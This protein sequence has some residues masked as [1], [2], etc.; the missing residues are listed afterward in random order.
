MLAS[1][2]R[3][4]T[5][6]PQQAEIISR[7]S[8]ALKSGYRHVILCAPTGVGKSHVAMTF[9]NHHGGG[10]IVTRQRLLQ[11][12]YARDFAGLPVAMG[13]S[14]YR[15]LEL[16]GGP[17]EGAPCS[18][19][20]CTWREG[21]KK[22]TCTRKPMPS[23]FTVLPGGTVS[24][25][26]DSC[27]YYTAKYTAMLSEAAVYNYASFFHF[28]RHGKARK[29]TL[30]CDEAHEIED[31]LVAHV[32]HT[33]DREQL[34]ECGAEVG[35]RAD[36]DSVR[37]ALWAIHADFAR[38]ARGDGSNVNYYAFVAEKCRL[39]IREA[40]ARPDNLVTGYG[41]GSRRLTVTMADVSGVA[42]TYFDAPRQ[43]FMS[44]T[45]SPEPFCHSMGI[46]V[47]DAAFVEVHDSPFP[48]ENRRIHM[49]DVARINERTTPSEH[50]A[51]CGRVNEVMRRHS[52]Q[53]GLILAT[54]VARCVEII[55]NAEEPDRLVPVFAR[56]DSTREEQLARHVESEE[57]TVL[58][59]PSL[60]SG[61]DL[62]G[63]LSEWQVIYK[64]PYPSM[65]DPRVRR[66]AAASQVWYR[67]AALTR[68][69]QGC[70]RSV[71][72]EGDSA[73]TYVIDSGIRDLLRTMKR[74]VPRSYT[75]ALA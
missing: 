7:I 43:L 34:D 15:C 38:R 39:L 66:K 60:W 1:F 25:P 22:M 71:R 18:Q 42:R 48:P 17:A 9:L 50:L 47:R 74:Y 3:G 69:L 54:S 14:N 27:L 64:V 70:G 26:A 2:P 61:V 63:R 31:A 58:L 57:P 8:E 13:K 59:S 62:R 44:A 73:P 75:D 68:F 11:H 5:P 19:G 40:E 53:K 41:S 72:E 16:D 35:P 6:R 24:G 4:A 30:V 65:S 46:D 21:G 51:A 10:G 49:L 33:V 32:T 56:G 52:G 20:R 55:R 36:V 67:Y 29:D 37:A 23:E 28:A 45:I 12:Q